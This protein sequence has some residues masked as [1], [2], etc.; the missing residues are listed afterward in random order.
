MKKVLFV[1]L[2]VV[3]SFFA[4]DTVQAQQMKIGVFDIEV[5]VQAMPKYRNVDSLVSMYE[6]DSLSAE[7]NVYQSEYKRLDST[8][9]ADSAAN[10]PKAIVE[11]NKNERQ[12]MA[13]NLVY[14]QQIAQQKSDNKR[15]QL[16][17]PL[18]EQ[19]LAAYQRVLAA[20]KYSLVLKPNSYD[21]VWGQTQVENVFQYVARELKI[22]NPPELGGDLQSTP[23]P[24]PAGK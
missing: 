2:A 12:K 15:A 10:K 18:F 24:R 20:R 23:A 8:Y 21:P 6:Q 7:Y 4:A 9:K 13:M 19:V 22:P 3:G 11:Y 14:W 5:M 17:N 16:A 1:M